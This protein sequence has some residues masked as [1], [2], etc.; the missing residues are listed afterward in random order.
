MTEIEDY[1]YT[2]N[3]D[4]ALDPYLIA[5]GQ[6]GWVWALLE[7]TINEVIWELANVSRHAGTCMTSQLI[8]PGPR[9]RCLVALLNLRN[10]P[11]AVIKE[12]NSLIT[13]A[14][15]L[16]RQRNRYLHDPIVW[17]RIN[18]TVH[19]ME[20]T[21]DRTLKH[22]IVPVDTKEI[23]KLTEAIEKMDLKLQDLF[24]R[25]RV[26]TPP[27]PRTEFERSTGIRRQRRPQSPNNSPSIS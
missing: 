7:F 23:V 22:D 18:K 13:D 17:H 3:Y 25:V 27:W 11:T 20:T 12:I 14:E 8:G 19:R 9:F 26:E 21:A 5:I 10:T 4:P 6:L 1:P 16:G 24:E 15:G 2:S